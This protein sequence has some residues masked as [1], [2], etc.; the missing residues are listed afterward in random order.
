MCSANIGCVRPAPIKCVLVAFGALFIATVFSPPCP[1]EIAGAYTLEALGCEAEVI[2]VGRLLDWKTEK[3]EGEQ[4]YEHCL[5]QVT[6]AIKGSPPRELRFSYLHWERNDDPPWRRPRVELLVALRRG[7]DRY[8]QG[9]RDSLFPVEDHDPFSI[10]NLRQPP[11]DLFDRTGHR[12]TERSKILSTIRYWANSGI[13]H[14]LHRE[15][16]DSPARTA[17]DSGSAVWLH[18]PADEQSRREIFAQAHS[19]ELWERA[20]AAAELWKFRGPETEQLLHKL[21]DDTTEV[22]GESITDDNVAAFHVRAAAAASLKKLG[23][24]PPDLPMERIR[25]AD[26][27]R[28]IREAY[29]TRRFQQKL[30]PGWRLRSVTA[31]PARSLPPRLGGALSEVAI[32]SVE[33]ENGDRRERLM[34]VPVQWPAEDYPVGY[35]L[36]VESPE[37]SGARIYFCEETMPAGTRAEFIQ[38]YKLEK[39]RIAPALWGDQP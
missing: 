3:G 25:P 37:N 26:E 22:V 2:A 15:T 19:P 8:G 5:L 6:E 23:V 4:I 39:T 28:A 24:T 33:L 13:R 29:W 11:D 16:W 35:A 18:V 31:G 1:A 27:R 20:E 34:L 7:G 32:I 21:L 14:T 17:L 9:R 10:F 12:V 36:G 30:P 38:F